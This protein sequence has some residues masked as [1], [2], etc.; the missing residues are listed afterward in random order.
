MWPITCARLKFLDSHLKICR[1]LVHGAPDDGA[2]VQ[3]SAC[4]RECTW[5]PRLKMAHVSFCSSQAVAHDLPTCWIWNAS[6]YPKEN[7]AE[8]CRRTPLRALLV[9][10]SVFSRIFLLCTTSCYSKPRPANRTETASWRTKGLRRIM[11]Q[12]TPVGVGIG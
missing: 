2:P 7:S 11:L 3:C 10:G 8:N 9:G 4:V 6:D 1:L 5:V 12:Q